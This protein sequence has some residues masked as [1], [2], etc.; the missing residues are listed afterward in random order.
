MT[1][2]ENICYPFIPV[3]GVYLAISLITNFAIK[4]KRSR[5]IHNL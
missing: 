3:V 2:K 1:A 4:F 5:V